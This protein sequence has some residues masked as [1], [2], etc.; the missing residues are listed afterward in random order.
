MERQEAEKTKNNGRCRYV[1]TF[2]AKEHCDKLLNLDSFTTTI[3]PGYF[4]KQSDAKKSFFLN[5]SYSSSRRPTTVK[6]FLKS[7]GV[8]YKEIFYEKDAEPK[9]RV[10]P[11]L[12][13]I[14]PPSSNVKNR[15]EEEERY[16]EAI[17]QEFEPQKRKQLCLNSQ[18]E[19]NKT[20]KCLLF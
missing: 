5:F 7:N 6:N 15:E 14:T 10:R 2:E 9:T 12:I 18:V 4:A 17:A 20:F 19:L 8:E 11:S 13:E 16:Q 3:K 1:L